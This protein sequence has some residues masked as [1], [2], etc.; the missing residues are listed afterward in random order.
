MHTA[1]RERLADSA[2]IF[3]LVAASAALY[4][5]FLGFYSDDWSFLWYVQM[6]GPT[7]SLADIYSRTFFLT[8][9][10]ITRPVHAVYAATL[11]ALFGD[12]PLGHHLVNTAMLGAGAVLYYRLLLALGISRSFA[13]ATAIVWALLPHYATVR[14]WFVCIQIPLSFVGY[15]VSLLADLRAAAERPEFR[16]KWRLVSATGLFVSVMSYEIFMPL[17]LLSPLLVAWRQRAMAGGGPLPWREHVP[18]AVLQ[19]AILVGCGIYKA[20]FTARMRPAELADHF[21]FFGR[22]VFDAA[23]VTVAGDFGV[24]LP[25]VLA[26]ILGRH[27]VGWAVAAAGLCGI[28]VFAWL[29]RALR[30][31]AASFDRSA[32]LPLVIAAAVIFVGGY[33][34]F[35]ITFNAGI[36]STGISNRIGLASS[37]GIALGLVAILGRL[38]SLLRSVAARKFVF[39][40]VVA[41]VAAAGFLIVNVIGFYW[42]EAWLR[43]QAVLASLAK[44]VPQLRPGSTVLLDGVCPYVGPSVVFDSWWD[45]A[46][47]V[48]LQY[49]DSSLAADVVS[50]RLRVT[51]EG[52][53]TAN[54]GERHGPYAYGSLLIYDYRRGTVEALSGPLDASRYFLKWNPG[55]DSGCRSFEEGK[56]ERLFVAGGP[57]SRFPPSLR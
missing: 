24:G 5:P 6:G 9:S 23:A 12:Q 47:A 35:F 53:Y 34:I 16:S 11:L 29:M 1:R 49:R 52:I 45:T 25:R 37:L 21:E 36:T 44:A 42:G 32:Y 50:P 10:I 20:V 33:S 54:W 18:F 27:E 22:L 28:V 17:F 15:A 4:L 38:V 13:L 48:R 30:S 3:A 46:G 7:M 55:R 31:E 39:A 40:G 2:F 56:G 14:Y 41:V 43:Q 26:D 51:E 57:V 8:N 19:L